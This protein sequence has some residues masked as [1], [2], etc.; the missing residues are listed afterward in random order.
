MAVKSRAINETTLAATTDTTVTNSG[1]SETREVYSLA[2]HDQA[3]TGGTVDLYLSDDAA[4]AAG[5]RIEQLV[6]GADE[7]KSFKPVFV[8]SDKYLIIRS[9]VADIAFHGAYTLR[10]GGDL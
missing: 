9:S 6:L 1:A 3:G 5:E 10:N 7:T 2:I 4:S 8:G